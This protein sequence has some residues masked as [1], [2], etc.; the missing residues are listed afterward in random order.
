MGETGSNGV[1]TLTSSPD[2]GFHDTANTLQIAQDSKIEFE[3]LSLTR[4]SNILTDVIDGTTLNLMATSSSPVRVTVTNDKS[5]LK[6][7]IQ[8]M[9]STYNDF[10]KLTEE[11]TIV[12]TEDEASG[13]LSNDVSTIRFIKAKVRDS[14]FSDSST[15]SGSVA[16]MRDI[17]IS[18]NQYGVAIFSESTY[19][20][21][22]ANNYEDVVTMLTADTDYQNLF[23]NSAKGLAQDIATMLGGITDAT[24]VITNRETGSE[25]DR[26]NYE[27][28]LTKLESRMD[29]VYERYLMQ[30]GAMETLMATM[31]STKDYLTA[32]F[33]SLSKV[34]D[35]K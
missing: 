12:G 3:G 26:A 34:Y 22:I 33:E 25:T 15:P 14:V 32:Q 29:G 27:K 23:G 13:A 31:D 16:A 24:G 6:T 10:L 8:G 4:S 7:N 2:L 11:L 9:V 17:G 30:F 28:E 19:N 20:A 1:F 5:T 21:A 18:I 35:Q